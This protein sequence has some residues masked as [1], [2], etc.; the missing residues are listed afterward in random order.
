[1]KLRRGG[2]RDHLERQT[3]EGPG[4]SPEAEGKLAREDEK[5]SQRRNQGTTSMEAKGIV[6]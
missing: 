3:E 5:D 4:Q 6:F 1:M 2:E